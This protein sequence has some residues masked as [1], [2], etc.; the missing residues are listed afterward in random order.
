MISIVGIKPGA[1]VEILSWSMRPL[2][3]PEVNRATLL[4]PLTSAAQEGLTRL[5][6]ADAVVTTRERHA[7]TLTVS[8]E[9]LKVSILGEPYQ[10]KQL[11]NNEAIGVECSTPIL[12]EIIPLEGGSLDHREWQVDK[13]G[14]WEATSERGAETFRHPSNPGGRITSNRTD[15]IFGVMETAAGEIRVTAPL[16]S[17]CI[18]PNPRGMRGLAPNAWGMR[19][20]AAAGFVESATPQEPDAVRLEANILSRTNSLAFIGPDGEPTGETPLFRKL[21]LPE[22]DPP[23]VL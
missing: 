6:D 15:W 21:A 19:A 4:I 13:P 7:A 5:D 9:A 1:R 12:L 10:D 18:A 3:R 11:R 17:D 20:F 14:G 8:S 23:D 16:Q 22:T 2:A